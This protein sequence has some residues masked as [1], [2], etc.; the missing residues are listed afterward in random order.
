[1]ISLTE[2][3][4]IRADF[5]A[6]P[7]RVKKFSPRTGY[8]LLE[9]V[10]DATGEY[11]ALRPTAAQLEG[12]EVIG[13]GSDAE[14][15]DPEAFFLQ[16]EAQRIRLAYQFDPMLAVSVSQ[17]D[18]LPHQIEAVY[19]HAL[20]MPRMRFLIADDPGAGKT[21]MAGLILKE[22]QYRGLV[23]RVLVVAPGHLK[24]Q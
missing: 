17:V 6:S 5:L 4:L 19:H 18:P 22:M 10:I 21:V 9:V 7:A 20:E 12:V 16:I 1:M 24:Y 13:A 8:A 3:Q 11:L 2:N 14:A 15:G 23:K